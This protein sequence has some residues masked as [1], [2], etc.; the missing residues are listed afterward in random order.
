LKLDYPEIR[1][2]TWQSISLYEVSGAFA[3]TLENL[4]ERFIPDE[5]EDWKWMSI[6]DVKADIEKQPEIYTVW[7]KIIFDE[8]D[9]Y[10]EDHKL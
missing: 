9:H 5:V 3:T 4:S 1:L 7:F 6:E 2:N 10:L 8:F